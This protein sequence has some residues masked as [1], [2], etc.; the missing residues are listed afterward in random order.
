MNEILALLPRIIIVCYVENVK[1]M[2]TSHHV[3]PNVG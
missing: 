2:V 1:V 3:A